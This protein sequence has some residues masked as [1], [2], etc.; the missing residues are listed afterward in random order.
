MGMFRPSR[1]ST[2]PL[3][4]RQ[5]DIA[6]QEAQLREKLE[7]LERIVTHGATP[8][9]NDPQAVGEQRGARAKQPEKRLHVSIA[10]E[11]G[12]SLDPGRSVGRP[13]ALRKQ[14]RE[15]RIIF[16]FLLMALAAAVIWLISHLHT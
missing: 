12:Q 14:R 10:L 8:I 13:R 2:P 5:Q 4:S 6:R 15:G 11:S 9:E 3:R 7:R 1:Q 16:L